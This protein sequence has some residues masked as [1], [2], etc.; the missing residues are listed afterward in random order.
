MGAGAAAGARASSPPGRAAAPSP[1]HPARAAVPA[2]RARTAA[3]E[4]FPVCMAL[5][6]EGL[7]E[8]DQVV[9]LLLGHVARD[10]VAVVGVVE[11]PDL[12][13]GP[14][15]PVVEERGGALDA[16]EVGRVER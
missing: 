9:E 6:S 4:G 13:Q 1:P 10:A 15:A 2:S 5:S 7:Q 16:D 8:L 12:L 14:R 11:G 3:A